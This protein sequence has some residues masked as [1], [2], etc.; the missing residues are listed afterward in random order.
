M[1]NHRW[2]GT[3]NPGR[4]GPMEAHRWEALESVCPRGLTGEAQGFRCPCGIPGLCVQPEHCHRGTRARVSHM[5]PPPRAPCPG[6]AGHQVLKP[7]TSNWALNPCA[8][9]GTQPKPGLPTEITDLVSGPNEAQ[10]LDVSS[11]KEFSERQS[12]R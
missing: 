8:R 1:A 12:D 10:A 5:E 11:Q 4:R 2:V 7:F 6:C 3:L 9:T